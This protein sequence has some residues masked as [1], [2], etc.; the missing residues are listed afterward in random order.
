MRLYLLAALLNLLDCLTTLAAV[1]RGAR[2]MN[3]L[4][5]S[6]LSLPGAFVAVKVLASIA[7]LVILRSLDARCRSATALASALISL[8]FLVDVVDNVRNFLLL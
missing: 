6:L 7:L 3:P 8:M 1:S 4:M 2:E 5:S